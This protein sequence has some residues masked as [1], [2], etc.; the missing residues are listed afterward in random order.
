MQWMQQN[1]FLCYKVLG[2]VSLCFLFNLF[3]PFHFTITFV[4]IRNA[5]TTTFIHLDTC[6]T[7]KQYT[8]YIVYIH[9]LLLQSSILHVCREQN[10]TTK[11]NTKSSYVCLYYKTKTQQNNKN[12][13]MKSSFASKQ[14]RVCCVYI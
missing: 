4:H 13:M 14:R 6:I 2:S 11:H 5:A 7:Y 9:L 8:Y 12:S 1:T 10:S 3:S